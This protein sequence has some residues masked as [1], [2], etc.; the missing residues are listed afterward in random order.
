MTNSIKYSAPARIDL[1]GGPTDWC[2]M[3]TVSMAIN[4][5][6]FATVKK[7]DNPDLVK[8]KIGD[9]EETY[10]EPIYGTK[11]DLFKA[12]I[13]LTELKGFEVS[14]TTEIPKGSGLGGS[15]PLT[16]S[17]VFALNDLFQKNWSKYY[18]TELAQRAETLKLQT[19]NGYQDQ[20]TAS[21]GGLIFMDFEGKACQKGSYSK[22]IEE[23]PY[24]VVERLDEYL[25]KFNI[26]VAIPE[27]IRKGSDETNS[28][29]SERYLNNDRKI[30]NLLKAK[31][32]LTQQ[33]KKAIIEKKTSK[34]FEIINQNNQM[35]R[36]LGYLSDNNEKMIE[37]ANRIGV[38][39]SKTTGAGK[40]AVAFFVEDE[41]R[42]KELIEEFSKHNFIK[43]IFKVEVDEGVQK[44][45]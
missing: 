4:L 42:Q 2:G 32:L 19:V 41:I 16:V 34:I 45:K 1:S 21:F 31:A 22:P 11:L 20:Y 14:Y 8:I 30:V 6:A 7:L 3:H 35:M 36:E 38:L 18:M 24:A 26:V 40:G 23:E 10:S 44:E 5:R 29:V 37:I 28:S 17:T 33:I 13:E 25:P 12:V 43:H 27:I 9:L 15:A 39:A